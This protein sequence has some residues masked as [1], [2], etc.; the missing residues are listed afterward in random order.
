MLIT[1]VSE[2]D[3]VNEILSAIGS[4]PVNTIDDDLNVDV[5]NAKRILN[6]VSREIQAKGWDFNIEDSVTLTPDFETGLIPC[7]ATYIKFFA[8]GYKLIRRSGYFFD[9]LSQTNK[10]TEG[11]TVTLIRELPFD[12]LPDI[13]RKFVTVR[14]C[15]V[16]QM[17]YLSSSDLDQHLA[18]EEAMAY[19]DVLDYELTSGSFNI[20]E[21]DT[22]I[23]QNI[24]RN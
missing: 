12:E 22:T 4:S 17:R 2:L 20:Y 18:Y 11:L 14:A 24:Q 1:P 6:G 8:D 10:F 9:N 5:V 7:P 23:S 19:A 13:F 16:F 3:A 21:D 15:R